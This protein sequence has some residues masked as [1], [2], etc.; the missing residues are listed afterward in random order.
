MSQQH[1]SHSNCTLQCSFPDLENR[2]IS[3]AGGVKMKLVRRSLNTQP[4]DAA[5][6]WLHSSY[7]L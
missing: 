5:S 1:Y 2:A 6:F 7:K 3:R 4:A